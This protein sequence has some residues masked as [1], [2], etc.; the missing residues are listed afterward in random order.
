MLQRDGGLLQAAR[1]VAYGKQ[2]ANAHRSRSD[3][4]LSTRVV[5][6]ADNAGGVVERQRCWS[7]LLASQKLRWSDARAQPSNADAN[8]LRQL[9]GTT[10][11]AVQR[12]KLVLAKAGREDGVSSLALGVPTCACTTLQHAEA[13]VRVCDYWSSKH[14][15]PV[16][17]AWCE[18]ELSQQR[19]SS[20]RV[21]CSGLFLYRQKF[22]Q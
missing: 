22:V 18:E 17:N 11:N 15:L 4:A 5:E 3:I 16:G 14:R 19:P 7:E 9:Q 12:L 6:A 2:V 10:V 1:Q 21:W 8:S 13:T 20:S